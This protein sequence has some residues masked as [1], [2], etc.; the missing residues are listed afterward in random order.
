[1]IEIKCLTC[2]TE[3]NQSRDRAK[4][5]SRKCYWKSKIGQPAWNKGIQSGQVPWNRGKI[6]EK[7]TVSKKCPVCEKDFRIKPHEY[8]KRKYC[9]VRCRS[10]IQIGKTSPNKGKKGLYKHTE[11]FKKKMS[12]RLTGVPLSPERCKQISERQMGDKNWA[13]RGGKL[14]NSQ[15]YIRLYRP[16]H[17]FENQNYVFE[18]RLVMEKHLGRYLEPNEIVHHRNGIKDDNRPENLQLGLRK[19]HFGNVRCPHC[20]KEFLIK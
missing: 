10:K 19:T 8:S 2:N 20:L 7:K 17:P 4:Y 11:E 3:F 15:G 13:W 5:C 6:F 12:E 18:H 14:K 16:E 1:M 9:S